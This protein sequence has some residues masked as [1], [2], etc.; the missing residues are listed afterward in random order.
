MDTQALWDFDRPAESEQRFRAALAS[1]GAY[2]AEDVLVLRTQL[3]RALGLQ[4][5]FEEA[6]AELSAVAADS[7]VSP[8]VR[9]Y[10]TLER[11]RVLRSSGDQL[12]AKPLFVN[13]LET[14]RSAGLDHLAVD[15]AHMLA[16]TCE[17][18]EQIP[19]ARRALEIAESSTDPRARRWVASVTHNLGWTLHDLGHY[20]EALAMWERALATRVEQAGDAERVRIAR[21]TVA[22]G[23]RSLARYDEALAIQRSLAAEGPADG[24]VNEE[25]GELLLALGQGHEAAPHFARA[26]ALLSAD[27]SLA[28]SDPARLTRLATLAS[29]TA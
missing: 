27:T 22:R 26:H 24:Y 21:W 15:A 19:W 20:D 16:I 28:E 9:T 2:S 3:A 4:R 12:G 23:L 5:R 13:A 1:G 17:G 8:L 29:P 25:I 11:G 7:S 6:T 10:L 18:D 14:A